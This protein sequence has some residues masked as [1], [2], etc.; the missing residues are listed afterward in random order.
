MNNDK[1]AAKQRPNEQPLLSTIEFFDNTDESLTV[2]KK[3][4]KKKIKDTDSVAQ[5]NKMSKKRKV[6]DLEESSDA[7]K[8]KDLKDRYEM[9]FFE[10]GIGND[11][12]DENL[13]ENTK[14]SSTKVEIKPNDYI[15]IDC[16]PKTGQGSIKKRIAHV[17]GNDVSKEILKMNFI[18]FDFMFIIYVICLMI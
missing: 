17:P 2:K 14:K 3:K 5:E 7:K 18:F 12:E 16:V 1:A 4:K 6:D 10:E 8:P 9:V 13:V 15:S 11:E